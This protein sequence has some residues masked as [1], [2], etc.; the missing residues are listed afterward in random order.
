MKTPLIFLLAALSVCARSETP[1]GE[2]P[3]ACDKLFIDTKLAELALPDLSEEQLQRAAELAGVKD[4]AG[5]IDR[6]HRRLA[7]PELSPDDAVLYI[8]ALN[9]WCGHACEQESARLLGALARAA[10]R[11]AT[12]EELL[13]R[14]RRLHGLH[15]AALRALLNN[16]APVPPAVAPRRVE[17]PALR[18][19]DDPEASL[20]EMPDASAVSLPAWRDALLGAPRTAAQDLQHLQEQLEQPKLGTLLAFALKEAELALP[21]DFFRARMG[22]EGYDEFTT[23]VSVTLL[24]DGIDIVLTPQGPRFSMCDADLRA[25]SRA[26]QLALHR[27]VLRL[28]VAERD[29]KREELL[30][31]AK[32][33]AGL[34]NRCN[35]WPLLLNQYELRGVSPAALHALVR[36][37]RGPATLRRAMV[38]T[39]LREDPEGRL[40]SLA[41]EGELAGETFLA[42]LDPQRSPEEKAELRREASRAVGLD[43]PP[44][45][46]GEGLPARTRLWYTAVAAQLYPEAWET[47]VALGPAA[48][49]SEFNRRCGDCMPRAARLALIEKLAEEEQL[50][51]A[52]RLAAE[53]LARLNSGLELGSQALAEKL[54]SYIAPAPLPAERPALVE[55]EYEWHPIGR[56]PFRGGIV[57]LGTQSLTLDPLGAPIVLRTEQGA[58]QTLPLSQLSEEDAEHV[59]DWLSR[60]RLVPWHLTNRRGVHQQPVVL[61]GRAERFIPCAGNDLVRAL[62]FG[63]DYAGE[64]QLLLRLADASWQRVG[65]RELSAEDWERGLRSVREAEG[66]RLLGSPLGGG[67]GLLRVEEPQHGSHAVEGVAQLRC[68][69]S[70]EEARAVAEAEGLPLLQWDLGAPGS[71]AERMWQRRMSD[72][73]LVDLCNRS[74]ALWISRGAEAEGSLKL[75][76]EGESVSTSMLPAPA[77]AS[78]VE[79]LLQL[80]REG[81]ADEVRALVTEKKS[82]LQARNVNGQTPLACAVSCGQKEVIA[83]LME[84]GADPL[85]TRGELP[86]LCV[87][88]ACRLPL[89]QLFFDYG[90]TPDR[91]EEETDCGLI[92]ALL[93]RDVPGAAEVLPLVDE[94]LAAGA[95]INAPASPGGPTALERAI[96]L[97]RADLVLGLMQRGADARG[98]RSV[99]GE[100]YPLPIGLIRDRKAVP[101]EVLVALLKGGYDPNTTSPAT[102][103]SM[104]SMAV[105]EG[106][107]ELVR[108]LLERGAN[109]NTHVGPWSVLMYAAWQTGVLACSGQSEEEH[110]AV[111][112]K[113]LAIAQLLLDYGADVNATTVFCGA[114]VS[115]L[116]FAMLRFPVDGSEEMPCC[117]DPRFARF[118]EERGGKHLD[119]SSNH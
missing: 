62:R 7:D 115:V 46:L 83:V 50:P 71:E 119:S 49:V 33:L 4:R 102:S 91:C 63:A 68:F 88:A 64:G 110:E 113:Q 35:A 85:D 36:D 86:P 15:P 52:T 47:L 80:I 89:Q 61:L 27:C 114:A 79:H 60:N 20:R 48:Q 99:E 82:L 12:P 3:R 74:C 73:M 87:A 34:L 58:E 57:A 14:L 117:A 105:K 43:L 6:L 96:A 5:L 2:A 24:R 112:Q 1:G 93:L 39:L 25:R 51:E 28:A 59:Q 104:L 10:E 107:T 81:R 30:R 67:A 55:G 11:G 56:R 53:W 76:S 26:L 97:R 44:L 66:L 101:Q 19:L 42:L 41:G 31:D 22:V 95:D 69:R 94:L 45:C 106:D 77:A 29:G 78:P 32:S 100:I 92:P 116:D 109:A 65:R 72:P 108:L 98:L 18:A 13:P 118:L 54:R 70:P 8:C 9:R 84:Q 75:S 17:A 40:A 90:Y 21:E 23:A 37:F 38:L 111:V 16:R 103:R